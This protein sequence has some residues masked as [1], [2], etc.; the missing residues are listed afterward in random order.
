MANDDKWDNVV[1][2]DEG[3]YELNQHQQIASTRK[4]VTRSQHGPRTL[5]ALL[6]GPFRDHDADTV[7]GGHMSP[8]TT[9]YKLCM[10][11]SLLSLTTTVISSF[12][13]SSGRISTAS[14][15]ALNCLPSLVPFACWSR[16]ASR[17]R[18]RPGAD[19]PPS[20]C[21]DYRRRRHPWQRV[22]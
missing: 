15:Y 13:L 18:D 17:P 2:R 1:V 10:G 22:C 7:A 8:L 4:H 21:V 9:T 11:V 5:A 19:L 3:Q 6:R 20:A 12:S 14:W 16:S